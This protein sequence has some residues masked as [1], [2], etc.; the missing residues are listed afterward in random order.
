MFGDHPR[1]VAAAVAIAALAV[2]AHASSTTSYADLPDPV[3]VEIDM[4]T[5]TGPFGPFD[6]DFGGGHVVTAT[7]DGA[8]MSCP[9][10]IGTHTELITIPS[11]SLIDPG[12]S[13]GR[14]VINDDTCPNQAIT[15]D[16]SE[17]VRAVGVTF[18]HYSCG[19]LQQGDRII[20]AFDGPGGTGNLVGAAATQGYAYDCFAIW[21]DFV[22]VVSDQ[23]DI[24]SMVILSDSDWT[25]FTGMAVSAG[26]ATAPCPADLDGDGAV[27][28]TDFLDLLAQWGTDP[29]GP[30]DLDGDGDVGVTDFLELLAAWG[31]CS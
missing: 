22:G 20:H 19:L 7:L 4:G 12:D 16:F 31:P 3:W 8:A 29:G 21:L 1:S 30:P 17:P 9:D 26:P 13:L 23:A 11:D 14:A 2:P 18:K 28:V 15:L 24:R 25:M 10:N 5:P 6:F 27:G